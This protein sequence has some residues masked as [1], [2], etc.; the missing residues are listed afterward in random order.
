MDDNRNLPDDEFEAEQEE[1]K[2]NWLRSMQTRSSQLVEQSKHMAANLGQTA[3]QSTQNIQRRLGEDY[4]AIIENEPVIQ[5]TFV[6]E[7][8]LYENSILLKTVYN[9]HWSSVL[10]WGTVAKDAHLN[11][12]VITNWS[13]KVFHNHLSR[14]HEVSQYMDSVKG[15]AHRLKFGH[16]IEYLPNIIQEFGVKKGVPGFYAH[17][18]QDFGSP[19]GIPVLPYSWN[20]KGYLSQ[21]ASLSASSATRLVSINFART[22]PMVAFA[23]GAKCVWDSYLN[24]RRTKAMRTYLEIA[25]LATEHRDYNAA[26]DNYKRAL[27]IERN[28]AI[29]IDLGNV[30]LQREKNWFRAHQTFHEALNLLSDDPTQT[31]IN[32]EAQLSLRGMVGLMT[33]ATADVLSEMHPE[34]WNEHVQDL[35]NATVFS[36]SQTASDLKSSNPLA[37]P[38]HF[39][40]AINYYLA[41]K[42]AC[43]YPFADER[44]ETVLFNLK[45]ALDA[46]GLVAR[47]DED[48]LRQPITVVKHLWAN[49]LVLPDELETELGTYL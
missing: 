22:L 45:Q 7:D 28:P 5:E 2:S 16:S 40:S 15:G 27:E 43:S 17:L 25:Q 14:Y 49:E 47:Y 8:L 23:M 18:L 41:A 42:A 12:K 21:Y 32:G 44:R 30:Y 26:I 11:E 46:L 29:L 6:L 37:T 13:D 20:V 10:L 38:P 9:T 34:Y 35:V 33:L 31:V 1:I 36:F 24:Q 39:S 19:A 3:Q 48:N 4:Y